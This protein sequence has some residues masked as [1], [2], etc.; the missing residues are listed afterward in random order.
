MDETYQV[1]LWKKMERLVENGTIAYTPAGNMKSHGYARVV[2]WIAESWAEL[3][4]NIF[5]QSF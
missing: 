2:E 1:V 3:Y 5:A 4:P